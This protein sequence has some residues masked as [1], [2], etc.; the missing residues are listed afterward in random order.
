MYVEALEN[1]GKFNLENGMYLKSGKNYY[2]NFKAE[3]NSRNENI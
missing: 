1:S 2:D 3:L